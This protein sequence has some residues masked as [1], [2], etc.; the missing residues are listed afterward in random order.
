[1]LFFLDESLNHPKEGAA[2]KYYWQEAND[3][4]TNYQRNNKDAFEMLRGKLEDL[5]EE[6]RDAYCRPF[7]LD[8][9]PHWSHT[10]SV[11]DAL[12][13]ELDDDS[14]YELDQDCMPPGQHTTREQ[15]TPTTGEVERQAETRGSTVTRPLTSAAVKSFPVA[16]PLSPMS[17]EDLR[18][19]GMND[20]TSDIHIEFGYSLTTKPRKSKRFRNKRSRGPLSPYLPR[21]HCWTISPLSQLAAT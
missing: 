6:H 4:L 10:S 17:D 9:D 5:K 12:R 1:M 8:E 7:S 11:I 15:A 18:M 19:R 21:P 3:L 14:M 16:E 2:A 13:I 20:E